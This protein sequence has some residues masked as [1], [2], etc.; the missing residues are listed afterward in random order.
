MC[1]VARGVC[2]WGSCYYNEKE[3]ESS[4]TFFYFSR[5]QTQQIKNKA[6]E[7]LL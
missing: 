1:A 2:V 6:A 4:V 3:T 5:L 7:A